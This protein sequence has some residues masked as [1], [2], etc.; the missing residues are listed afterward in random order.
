MSI[1][2]KGHC[3]HEKVLGW[4]RSCGGKEFTGWKPHVSMRGGNWK[5]HRAWSKQAAHFFELFL[6]FVAWIRMH[7]HIERLGIVLRLLQTTTE[8]ERLTKSTFKMWKNKKLIADQGKKREITTEKK[9]HIVQAP[10]SRYQLCSW[11]EKKKKKKT[12]LPRLSQ[13]GLLQSFKT[14]MQNSCTF[15]TGGR[16]KKSL[17]RQNPS[18]DKASNKQEWSRG[19]EKC[20]HHLH[21]CFKHHKT[22]I[23]LFFFSSRF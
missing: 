20:A 13:T 6:S 21:H 12:G 1:T 14:S 5:K 16:G 11:N 9:N 19:E 18:R 22:A 8:K 17:I 3:F 7:R 10:T 2:P 23:T 4:H 15:E